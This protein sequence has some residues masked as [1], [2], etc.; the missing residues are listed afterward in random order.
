M[1]GL[2]G[3]LKNL[4]LNILEVGMHGLTS[5][6]CLKH[7][8]YRLFSSMPLILF[9]KTAKPVYTTAV[10]GVGVNSSENDQRTKFIKLWDRF[11]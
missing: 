10:L 8:R 9:A 11:N 5:K 4:V 7:P 2:T 1:V 6:Y 3:T